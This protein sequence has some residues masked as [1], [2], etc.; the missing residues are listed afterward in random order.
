MVNAYFWDS[1]ALVKRYVA[2]TGTSW[3]QAVTGPSARNAHLVARITWV[4]VTS[5]LARRQREGSL[6]PEQVAKALRAFRFD[7]NTQFRVVD[8]DQP[9]AELAGQL[10]AR[11]PL[12]AY[13][14][15]QMASALRIHPSFSSSRSTS[16]T[17][18]AADDRLLGAAEA[19]GLQVDNPNH[20]P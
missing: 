9:L 19:E 20:H 13:D 15:V 11:H 12:R 1:S 14:A 3:V 8:L 17:F 10:L 16:L 7:W 5:A 2:E 6:S 4:E 18:V